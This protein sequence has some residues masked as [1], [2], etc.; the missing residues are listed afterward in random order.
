MQFREGRLKLQAVLQ[1]GVTA[2]K[3]NIFN[4]IIAYIFAYD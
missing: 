2:E 4:R 1:H 3:I